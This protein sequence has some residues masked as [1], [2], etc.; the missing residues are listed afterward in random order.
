MSKDL[1]SIADKDLTYERITPRK[2]SVE[3]FVQGRFPL[4]W[5]REHLRDPA[6]RLLLTLVAYS[7]M[8]RSK[9]VPITSSLLEDAGIL[10]RRTLYRCL[11]ALEKRS[12]VAVDRRKGARAVVHN[13]PE[14]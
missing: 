14:H 10:E 13:L 12:G 6:D 5:I 8:T 3:R 11:T 4:R 2:K 1:A 9:K 7:D